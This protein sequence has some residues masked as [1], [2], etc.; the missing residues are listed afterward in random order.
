M[1]PG[2]YHN[3]D[4]IYAHLNALYFESQISA[5]IAWGRHRTSP[6][7]RKYSIRLGSYE[8]NSRHI[9]IHP[10]LDQAAVPRLCVERIVYHEMLHQK[11]PEKRVSRSK[12]S[13]HTPEFRAAEKLFLGAD[14]ADAW[15]KSNIEQILA[16]APLTFK[17]ES[18]I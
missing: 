7:R 8:P 16:Y 3:L 5:S 15:F 12:R 18:R 2:I 4:I 17:N 10:A 6:N 14:L 9:T 11:F 1:R 13:I